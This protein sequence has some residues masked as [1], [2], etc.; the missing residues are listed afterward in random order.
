MPQLAPLFQGVQNNRSH[1]QTLAEGEAERIARGEKEIQEKKMQINESNKGKE[2]K[3]EIE[4][5]RNKIEKLRVELGWTSVM[6]SPVCVSVS[7]P[8]IKSTP[9]LPSFI[10]THLSC[11]C[12]CR[13]TWHGYF[14]RSNTTVPRFSLVTTTITTNHSR[15]ALLSLN[16]SLIISSSDWNAN[17]DSPP[18]WLPCR[19]HIHISY[20]WMN[21]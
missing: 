8:C 10:I 14:W 21:W 9:S 20:I 1:W 2:R 17:N 15:H 11:C 3:G 12:C 4:W 5:N 13:C 6:S 18:S 7:H 16:L 19:T